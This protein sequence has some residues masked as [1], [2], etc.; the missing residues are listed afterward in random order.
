MISIYI[1]PIWMFFGFFDTSFNY[2]NF[3]L[4]DRCSFPMCF[5]SFICDCLEFHFHLV[6]VIPPTSSRQRQRKTRGRHAEDTRKTRGR[7]A[8]DMDDPPLPPSSS[9]LSRRKWSNMSCR[10]VMM[11]LIR[12]KCPVSSKVL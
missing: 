11:M 9:F 6:S 10:M 1:F 2:S 7:H 5:Y 8:E 3:F 4:V 12:Q